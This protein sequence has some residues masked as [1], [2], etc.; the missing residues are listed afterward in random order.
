VLQERKLAGSLLSSGQGYIFKAWPKP[1][2]TAAPF[3]AAVLLGIKH[4]MA[5]AWSTHSSSS[6][7]ST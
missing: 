3:L 5:K 2:E 7:S 4:C 6:S 1:G